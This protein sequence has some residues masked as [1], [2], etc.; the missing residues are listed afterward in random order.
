MFFALSL[1]EQETTRKGQINKDVIE[2]D[3]GNNEN[4]KYKVK[5]ICDSAVYA[6]ESKGY[7]PEL[8]YFIS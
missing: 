2:L 8:Y 6:R 3:A 1:L 4:R 5:A 7:L